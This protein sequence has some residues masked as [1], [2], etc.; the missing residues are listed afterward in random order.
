[1]NNWRFDMAAAGVKGEQV[2]LVNKGQLVLPATVEVRYADGT[3]TR[4]RVPVETWES[5]GE[6]VWTGER[7]IASAVIDPDHQ[8]PDD[9]RSDNTATAR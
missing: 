2:T 8:L 6:T 9:N 4:F 3:T 5:K 7:P 1:M